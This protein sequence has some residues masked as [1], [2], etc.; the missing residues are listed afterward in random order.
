MKYS[1]FSKRLGGQGA[2]AW[3]LH[4]QALAA[5]AAGEDVIVMSVGDSD[6]DTPTQI[7]DAC[8]AALRDGD[9]HYTPVAGTDR[10]RKIVASRHQQ[11]TGVSTGIGNVTICAGTQN[12]LFNAAM[13]A[14][15]PGDEV[16]VLEPMYVTYE[17]TFNATGATIVPLACPPESD[18]HPDLT[19]LEAAISDKTTAIAFA[20]PVNPTGVVFSR[21]ELETIAGVAMENDLW[22]LSDE[23][24]AGLVF[25]GEHVS[26]A[27]LA[28]MTERTITLGSLSKSHAMPGWR[29]G[30]AVAPEGFATQMQ[31]LSLCS[32]Y[33][34][35]GFIQQAAAFALEMELDDVSQMHSGLKRKRDM[36]CSLLSSTSELTYQVPQAGM[37]LV[38]D[39]SQTG[40]ASEEF[41]SRL[42]AEEGV[43]VLDGS[44]FGPSTAGTIRISFAMSEQLLG[45]GC[46][47]ILKFVQGLVD[48][49]R[50]KEPIDDYQGSFGQAR[51]VL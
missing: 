9:T 18:F 16:V 15:S 37:F 44:A 24:Y 38:V 14:L 1:S 11:A 26:I 35:P 42:Y 27:S 31:Q 30:W 25:D 22:V 4:F 3:E 41:A 51:D 46:R 34:L 5:A 17:A 20:S 39:I 23:V 7:V 10:F 32:T 50:Q 19:G 2:G 49:L 29:A 21:R 28:G 12:A 43:S 6:Y 33:G 48:Y 13:T 45:E 36:A 47:R 8:I 40:L